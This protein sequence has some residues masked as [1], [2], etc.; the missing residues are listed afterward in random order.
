MLVVFEAQGG[1]SREVVGIVHKTAGAVAE[2]E[3]TD[4]T[5]VREDMLQ[6]LALVRGRANALAIASRRAVRHSPVN[7]AAA[8]FEAATAHLEEPA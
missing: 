1:L 3:H 6:W 7:V 2:L 8:Q 4:P 5:K